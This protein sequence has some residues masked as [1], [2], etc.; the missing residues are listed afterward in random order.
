[1]PF[2]VVSDDYPHM[3]SLDRMKAP[4][5]ALVYEYG[6]TIVAEMINAGCGNNANA[7]RR[8]LETWRRR[9]QQELLA[10]DH[11]VDPARLLAI[12]NRFRSPRRYRGTRRTAS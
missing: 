1:V 10:Q 2:E 4:M 3:Q 6:Y 5:R 8:D 7:L 11:K 9:R 12:A